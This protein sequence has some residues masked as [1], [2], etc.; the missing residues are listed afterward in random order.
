MF[1]TMKITNYGIGG[2]YTPHMDSVGNNGISLGE[3][4]LGDRIATFLSYMNTVEVG[5]ATA[6]PFLGIMHQ[7]ET[8]DAIF[9]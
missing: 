9:W 5:G 7:P 1:Q 2:L 8:G 6:F 3:P 4:Y